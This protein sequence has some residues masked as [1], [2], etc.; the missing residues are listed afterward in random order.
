LEPDDGPARRTRPNIVP[1]RAGRHTIDRTDVPGVSSQ[2]TYLGDRDHFRAQVDD[3]TDQLFI[4]TPVIGRLTGRLTMQISRRLR[5]PDGG[6][7]GTLAA[8]RPGV[9]REIS[10]KHSNRIAGS[11]G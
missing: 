5:H 6:F 2:R 7:A 10:K 4:G 8:S 3:K 11:N 9:R 1:D